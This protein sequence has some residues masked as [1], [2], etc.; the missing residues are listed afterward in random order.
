MD[1]SYRPNPDVQ[2]LKKQ[3]FNFGSKLPAVTAQLEQKVMPQRAVSALR[4]VS[5]SISGDLIA[6]TVVNDSIP[7]LHESSA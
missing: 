1:V 3:S 4:S 5:S 2:S 6:S 7:L